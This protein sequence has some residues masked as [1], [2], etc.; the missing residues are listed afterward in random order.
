MRKDF[1]P[2]GS[3]VLLKGMRK[4]MMICGRMQIQKQGD[5]EKLFDYSGCLYPE[6]MLD[7]S[8]VYLFNHTDIVMIYA[9]GLQDQEEMEL[10]KRMSEL[11]E[12]DE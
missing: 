1:L 9:L 11:W 7:A 3:V 5:E 2:I 10:R 6:G 4:R 12:A 8:Q